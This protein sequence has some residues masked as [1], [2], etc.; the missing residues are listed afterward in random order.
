[1]ERKWLILALC[2]SVLIAEGCTQTVWQAAASGNRDAT[3]YLL[4]IH[5]EQ[6]N[7]LDEENQW[8]PLQHA[9]ANSY[10]DMASYLLSRGADPSVLSGDG[11]DSITF[12]RDVRNELMRT[13]ILDE[14]DN[15]LAARGDSIDGF[16]LAPAQPIA[17]IEPAPIVPITNEAPIDSS[18]EATTAT[19]E[20]VFDPSDPAADTATETAEIA[21]EVSVESTTEVATDEVEHDAT[22]AEDSQATAE[23]IEEE[24]PD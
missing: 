20:P 23:P 2:G 3:Q 18:F 10:G 4:E 16:S 5:P 12:A 22:H 9:I 13:Y 21:T 17:P 1:M 6:I 19:S 24:L 15:V 14:I 11:R 8:T 7:E